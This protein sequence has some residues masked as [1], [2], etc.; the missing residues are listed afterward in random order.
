MTGQTL[1][2][3]RHGECVHNVERRVAAQDDSPLTALGRK[4]AMENGSVL[5]SLADD[6][7]TLDY[8]ASPLHRAC[9]TMEILRAAA[10]LP[11][12]AYRADR[13]LM[14]M[15]FGEDTGKTY[16][17]IDAG[18]GRFGAQNW[19]YVRPGGESLAMLHARIG[20]FLASLTRDALVVTHAGPLRMIRAHRLG[21]SREAALAYH[22]PNAGIVRLSA[23]A[24]TVF[25]D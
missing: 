7:A 14:E 12:A 8:V 17:E 21:L 3:V 9:V 11:P 13:R 24:E 6:L 4:Q 16:D 15:D 20:P 23:G 18:P 22:P 10:G 5:K 2:L 1:Y 19:D 25:G